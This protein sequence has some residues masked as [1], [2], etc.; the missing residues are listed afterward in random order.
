MSI[1]HHV[2]WLCFLFHYI[3]KMHFHYAFR[4]R[5][6]SVLILLFWFVTSRYFAPPTPPIDDWGVIFRRRH[7]RYCLIYISYI[8]ESASRAEYFMT[9]LQSDA[10]ISL[11]FMLLAPRQARSPEL[12]HFGVE[13][14]TGSYRHFGFLR[15][16][17]AYASSMSPHAARASYCHVNTLRKR[18]FRFRRSKEAMSA[19]Q[20]Y[21]TNIAKF[22]LCLRHGSYQSSPYDAACKWRLNCML[23]RIFWY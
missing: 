10:D 5:A 1:R 11:L 17:H 14:V 7:L 20:S 22:P 19:S 4:E 9:F 15:T 23:P 8:G 21:N 12:H 6:M 16:G 13:D 18:L 2:E 3:S